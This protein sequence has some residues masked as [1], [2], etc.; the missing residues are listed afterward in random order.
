MG[1][2]L[3][4]LN[5]DQKN[6]YENLKN[7]LCK[8]GLLGSAIAQYYTDHGRGH[9]ERIIENFDRIIPKN[10]RLNSTEAYIL[11]CSAW[12]HDIATAFQEP[13]KTP[14]EIYKSHHIRGKEFIE[15]DPAL[16]NLLLSSARPYIAM[17]TEKHRREEKIDGLPESVFIGKDRVRIRLLTALLRLADALDITEARASELRSAFVKKLPDEAKIHWKV[18]SLITGWN[19]N[20]SKHIIEI[21]AH[22]ETDEEK[23]MLIWKIDDL[24][25][26]LSS[27]IPTLNEYGLICIGLEAK[28]VNKRSGEEETISK[29]I[30]FVERPAPLLTIVHIDIKVKR[31]GK[32]TYKEVGK[33]LRKDDFNFIK[34]IYK[35]NP[36]LLYTDI[37]R[38]LNLVGAGGIRK[39]R[40]KSLKLNDRQNSLILKASGKINAFNRKYW[41]QLSG[42]FITKEFL[43]RISIQNRVVVL[44]GARIGTQITFG[45]IHLPNNAKDPKIEYNFP[46]PGCASIVYTL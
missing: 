22:Y 34:N 21:S 25:S 36:M 37:N 7:E 19:F 1:G 32:V 31:T 26:E 42:V 15:N 16:N 10:L 30:K 27:V 44:N 2:I 9:S 13:G 6:Y 23:A 46:V 29:G 17:I 20:H 40:I 3:E 11:L 24:Y 28:L 35:E 4:K 18:C 8:A 33:F 45:K 38:L 41:I 14:A 43:E 12:L 5:L 39:I